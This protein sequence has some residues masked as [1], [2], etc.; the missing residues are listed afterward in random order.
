MRINVDGYALR[1][2]RIARLARKLALPRHQVIGQ[3]IEVWAVCYDRVTDRLSELDID[4]AAERDGFAAAMCDPQ[5]ELA[6]RHRNGTVRISGAAKRI[7]YLQGQ[8]ERGARG[9]KRS[10]ETRSS[11]QTLPEPEA[12]QKQTLPESEAG[13]KPS[14]SGSFSG[15]SSSSGSTPDPEKNPLT[16]LA[17]GTDGSAL[18]LT[19]QKP[20]RRSKAKPTDPTA[21]ESAIALRVLA[22]LTERTGISYRG[23]PPHI[24]LIADRLREGVTERELRG[25]AV[26]CWSAA[27]RN[28][29]AKTDMH[30]Y[31]CPETLFGPRTIHKYLPGAKTFLAEHY[32]E[33]S[34]S[35]EAA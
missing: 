3:L 30:Q 24:R 8:Q 17:G 32:P 1:D 4:T 25:I 31:L 16:P 19:E 5:I 10:A 15:S 11:K 20:R 33:A 28:W 12:N 22:K 14:G 9:G 23:S 29:E 13:A 2:P 35:S 21:E 7:R 26:Y 27:G 6:E 34:A 18:V